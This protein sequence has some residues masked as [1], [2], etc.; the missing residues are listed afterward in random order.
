MRAAY[1]ACRLRAV[2]RRDMSARCAACLMHETLCLCALVPRL[3]VST[4]LALLVHHTEARK[5]TNTGV[6]AAKCLGG[7][8]IGYIGDRARPL[9]LPIV[10]AGEAGVLLFPA[11]DAE[12][13]EAIAPRLGARAV[14][15]VPD[16]N[17]RQAAKLRHRVPG[18]DALPCATV[19][20]PGRSTYRL[21]AEPRDDG[22]ATLE[23]IAHAMRVLEGDAVADALLAIFR[24]MVDR[25]LWLRGALPS[26]DVAGGIPAAALER[27]PRGAYQGAPSAGDAP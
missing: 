27:D 4:R 3:A 18:L 17:W 13:L 12:P 15:V 24:V 22:L 21:R 8:T 7:S 5:P 10:R 1:R 11:D 16:G 14:L 19:R 25:T 26:A 6:L 9:E 20:A 2:S 23:A